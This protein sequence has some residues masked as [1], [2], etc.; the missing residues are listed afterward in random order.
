M[1]T[2]GQ[3]STASDQITLTVHENEEH[4]ALR[5]VVRT[6]GTTYGVA[7][8]TACADAGDYPT[9]LWR[10]AGRLADR[11]RGTP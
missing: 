4:R 5:E 3:Q 8:M 7:Y 2:T 1:T 10:E 9:E 6:L 11:N